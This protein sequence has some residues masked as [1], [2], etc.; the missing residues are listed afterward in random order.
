MEIGVVF[1]LKLIQQDNYYVNCYVDV[2]YGLGKVVLE[3]VFGY[4]GY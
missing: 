4:V 3:N 1:F 2:D